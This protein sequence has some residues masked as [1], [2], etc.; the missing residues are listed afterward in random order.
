MDSNV[1]LFPD[2][3][4]TVVLPELMTEGMPWKQ[5]LWNPEN[6]KINKQNMT[7]GQRRAFAGGDD[8]TI[9]LFE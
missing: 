1:K 4:H 9:T 2:A 7:L 6:G 5:A 8:N 3:G